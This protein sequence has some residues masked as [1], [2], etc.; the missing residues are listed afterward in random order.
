MIY[1]FIF[2][3]LIGLSFYEFYYK[4]ERYVE[5]L[6]FFFLASAALIIFS[7][8]R[9]IG[10]DYDNYHFIF[11]TVNL[12]NYEENTIEIGFAFAIQV[13][14]FLN[15]PFNLFLFFIALISVGI[16]SIFI[17][18]FS[19]YYFVSLIVYF[20][21]NFLLSDMGQIRH[22]L[23][24]SIALLSFYDIFNKNKRGFVIKIIIAYLFHS[25]AIIVFPAYFIANIKKITIWHLVIPV[26][27]LLPLLFIDIK[28]VFI[29]LAAYLPA[30][31]QSKIAYYTTSEEFGQQ[32]GFSLTMVL[33]LVIIA[34][35]YFY[36]EEGNKQIK[37]YKHFFLLYIYGTIL[38]MAFNSIAEMAVRFSN[39]FKILEFI[40]LPML[41]TLGR[42][43]LEKHIIITI[44]ILYSG[45]SLYKLLFDQYTS[46]EYL[47]YRN[48]FLG[49]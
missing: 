12:S 35:M 13:F 27:A 6:I 36:Y 39:Y 28:G 21:V 23:A 43:L 41:V 2:L 46:I 16:K 7:G 26:V 3:L 49:D 17:K 4:E 38:F 9:L 48:L 44:I 25:S 31:I 29:P 8:F 40:I 33:R 32:L 42:T 11:D 5:V 45:W 10:F 37:F 22:G 34:I 47:P 1:Y 14:H 15:L 18:D 19:P 30:Q 24:M 20:T